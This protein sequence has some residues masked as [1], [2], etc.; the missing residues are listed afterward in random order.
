MLP[1]DSLRSQ[2]YHGRYTAAAETLYK[3][4]SLMTTVDGEVVHALARVF[5]DAPM[6]S[7][8]IGLI[9]SRAATALKVKEE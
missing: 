3:N 6:L 7:G 1:A 4:P 2:L 8:D 5:G 9:A